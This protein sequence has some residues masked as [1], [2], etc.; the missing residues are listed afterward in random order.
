MILAQRQGDQQGVCLWCQVGDKINLLSTSKRIQNSLSLRRFTQSTG[1][2]F[3]ICILESCGYPRQGT[4]D[5]FSSTLNLPLIAMV[6]Y[7]LNSKKEAGSN[8]V[9]M[10]VI[11][12]SDHF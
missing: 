3:G 1:D 6:L 7:C 11:R 12:F 10:P 2:Q 9:G 8:T 4:V 5:T